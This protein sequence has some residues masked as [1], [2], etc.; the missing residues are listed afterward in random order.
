MDKVEELTQRVAEL[1]ASV[2]A[3]ADWIKRREEAEFRARLITSRQAADATGRSEAQL[4]EI[5]N[6]GNITRH[7]IGKIWMY[8]AQEI[9][10]VF[11]TAALQRLKSLSRTGVPGLGCC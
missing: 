11:G 9:A 3:I 4:V 6:A 10:K 1:A 2:S 5:A 7:K 8:D